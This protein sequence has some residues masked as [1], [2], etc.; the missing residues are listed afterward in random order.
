M[1]GQINLVE[2][3]GRYRALTSGGTALQCVYGDE[4]Y[5]FLHPSLTGIAL[6]AG[7]LGDKTRYLPEAGPLLELRKGLQMEYFTATLDK[8]ASKAD[9]EMGLK[10]KDDLDLKERLKI[11]YCKDVEPEVLIETLK[12]K[13]GMEN[14]TFEAFVYLQRMLEGLEDGKLTFKDRIVKRGTKGCMYTIELDEDMRLGEK[15]AIPEPLAGAGLYYFRD[16][17]LHMDVD[18]SKEIAYQPTLEL[19]KRLPPLDASFGSS[20][21]GIK[22]LYE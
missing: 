1:K 19:A 20:V 5:L 3:K 21:A 15:D 12:G 13:V 10:Q 11:K 17:A 22:L 18:F 9:V 16:N 8:A 2:T 14:T 4:K 6:V 7:N